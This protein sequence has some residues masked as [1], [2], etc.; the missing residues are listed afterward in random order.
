MGD[1]AI[2][3]R[4]V[5]EHRAA[6]VGRSSRRPEADAVEEFQGGGLV[7]PFPGFGMPYN[8]TGL[9]PFQPVEFVQFY[10]GNVARVR[11]VPCDDGMLG[12]YWGIVYLRRRSFVAPMVS[13]SGFNLIEVLQYFVTGR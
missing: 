9:E 1:D 4:E 12:L 6:H 13:H 3:L 2:V 8:A 11:A 10:D 7:A 5:G